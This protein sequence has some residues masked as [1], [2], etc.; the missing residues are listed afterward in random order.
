MSTMRMVSSPLDMSDRAP[1]APRAGLARLAGLVEAGVF[2]TKGW[3]G[4]VNNLMK[5]KDLGDSMTL[6]EA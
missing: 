3:V 2:F 6:Q 4:P 1:P 5:I